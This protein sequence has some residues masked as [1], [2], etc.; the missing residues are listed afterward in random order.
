MATLSA[1]S[2]PGFFVAYI[3]I[4]LITVQLSRCPS[5]VSVDGDKPLSER[6]YQT[7]LPALTMALIV[8][9]HML[10][11]TRAAVINLLALITPNR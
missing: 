4:L 11:V 7:F 9:A 3:L 2:F 10:R 5:L 8:M 6:R 1:I